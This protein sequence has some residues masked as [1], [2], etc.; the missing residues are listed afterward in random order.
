MATNVNRCTWSKHELGFSA[1]PSVEMGRGSKLHDEE[2]D[3]EYVRYLSNHDVDAGFCGLSVHGKISLHVHEVHGTYDVW[4]TI[5]GGRQL[6]DSFDTKEEAMSELDT[7]DAHHR[8]SLFR[9]VRG[10][11]HDL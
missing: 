7:F 3:D 5:P 4:L 10:S 1:H 2:M 6:W 8:L 9:P 11:G